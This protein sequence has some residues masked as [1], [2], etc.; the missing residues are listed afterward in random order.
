MKPICIEM[1]RAAYEYYK[2]NW[3]DKG[4]CREALIKYLDK[5][6]GYMGTVVDIAITE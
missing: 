1:T 3:K 4:F 6:G 5:A 2:N